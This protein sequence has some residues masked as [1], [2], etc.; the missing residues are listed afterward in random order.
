MSREQDEKTLVRDA[1]E[2]FERLHKTLKKD[3]LYGRASP[4]TVQARSELIAQL[5]EFTEKN[6]ALRAEIGPREIL[7]EGNTV[8]EST[9]REDNLAGVFQRDG[10]RSLT[11][12]PGLEPREA[13][14]FLDIVVLA[15]GPSV[16]ED[17][18]VTL[19][20]TAEL[21]SIAVDAI[22]LEHDVDSGSG[23]TP[24]AASPIPW[25]GAAQSG[26]WQ[27]PQPADASGPARSDDWE[28]LARAVDPVDSFDAIEST[29]IHE[30]AR[31]QEEQEAEGR[32]GTLAG[33]VQVLEQVLDTPT[34]DSDRS[35]LA[36][37]LPRVLS[38]AMAEGDWR[39]AG[40]A[41]GLLRLCDAAWSAQAFLNG[42]ELG[43][44]GVARRAAESVDRQPP[45][46]LGHLVE[47]A[48]ALGVEGVDWLM[49]LLAASTRRPVRLALI[50]VVARL[51][52]SEPERILPWLSDERW[53]VVRNAIHILGRIGGDDQFTL[54]RS[55]SR[56][57]EPRVRR[58]LVH[59]IG[60]MSP[61]LG[62]P[63]LLQMLASAESV[64]FTAILGQLSRDPDAAVAAHLMGLLR[65]AEFASR[66]DA[67]R[68]A[69]YKAIAAQG[70]A[71][72]SELEAELRSGSIFGRNHDQHWQAVARCLAQIQSPASLAAL[73]RGAAN[74]KP[75]VAKACQLALRRVR[76]TDG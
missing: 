73:E 54:L 33:I 22:Q 65:A 72:V 58:E 28:V 71:V 10:I 44:E 30:V 39:Q 68:H 19:L 41:L 47:F 32:A 27:Q 64:L 37:F 7:V 52:A 8:Y 1:S 76:K 24:S 11:F 63:M 38:E 26:L 66:P 21:P 67:D 74:P 31:F 23:E 51:A 20:W 40:R 57:P 4:T 6:G 25:P 55:A 69:L 14:T 48:D 16:L 34:L 53:Y 62:R 9:T 3:R 45:E 61:A 13:E 2:W 18:L 36:H 17:D 59:A 70:D 12:R 15:M 46:V 60:R 56:H 50:D 42:L 35:E 75:G 5:V 29:A 49:R 43:T